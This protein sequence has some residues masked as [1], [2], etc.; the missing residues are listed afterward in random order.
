MVV[1]RTNDACVEGF[2]PHARLRFLYS[3]VSETAAKLQIQ[4]GNCLAS[5]SVLARALAGIAL[6]GI[7]LGEQDETIS[8]HAEVN[9]R[10]GGFFAEMTGRGELRGYTHNTDFDELPPPEPDIPD[11]CGTV[12][13]VKLTRTHESGRI[14]SQMSFSVSPASEQNIL[15]EFYNATMQ[16][17]TQVCLHA[18][19]FDNR[20]E[21]ARAL[22]VQ[23]MPDGRKSDFKR[24]SALFADGTVSEQ[25][26]YDASVNTLREIFELPDLT[27]GPTRALAFG[28][29]CSQSVAEASYATRSKPELDGLVRTAR[30]QTFRCHLCGKV[31]TL[32]PE[33]LFQLALAAK[34]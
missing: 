10:V 7:D 16:I 24:I 22:A 26:E 30:P 34:P 17:P 29:T 31:Y 1:A 18:A 11:P 8:M 23:L 13:R 2:S 15:V 20:I 5:G 9:G 32:T 28:C 21:R 14:R 12:A 27:T 19:A 33:K 3:D 4:H 25:L 6:V